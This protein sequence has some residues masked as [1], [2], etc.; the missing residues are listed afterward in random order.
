MDHLYQ[1]P[2]QPGVRFFLLAAHKAEG[3][4]DVV[5]PSISIVM[6]RGYPYRAIAFTDLTT[7][8]GHFINAGQ[9][10]WYGVRTIVPGG[11]PNIITYGSGRPGE[12]PRG[13]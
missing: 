7:D 4:E 11:E 12:P 13:P 9:A 6:R 1:D 5:V 3:V 2:H 8:P 10:S